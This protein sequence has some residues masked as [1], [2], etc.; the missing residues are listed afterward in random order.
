MNCV[1]DFSRAYDWDK[2]SS[3]VDAQV[4]LDQ[5]WARCE[6]ERLSGNQKATVIAS[7]L[8]DPTIAQRAV[9][10]KRGLSV[11]ILA[12]LIFEKA[13]RM[14]L[15]AEYVKERRSTMAPELKAK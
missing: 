11:M 9:D 6:T 3:K 4:F 13:G 14:E 5:S 10:A 7:R 8:F 1:I 2:V 12:S 15:M